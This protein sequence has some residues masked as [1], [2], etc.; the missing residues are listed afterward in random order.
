MTTIE[1]NVRQEAH[2]I[3]ILRRDHGYRVTWEYPGVAVILI[4]GPR[5]DDPLYSV[6]TGLNGWEYGSV[7][8]WEHDTWQP[9]E[10]VTAEPVLR[11]FVL[12]GTPPSADVAAAWASWVEGFRAGVYA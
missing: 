10:H 11:S 1:L 9:V 2:V 4:T 3:G 6:S 5:H 7:S 12:G 8:R